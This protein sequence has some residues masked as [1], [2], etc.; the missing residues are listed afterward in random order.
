MRD[1]R[2]VRDAVILHDLG[3]VVHALES[4]DELK[5]RSHDGVMVVR[6]VVRFPVNEGTRYGDAGF[7]VHG[8]P[9]RSLDEVLEFLNGD[10]HDV[11]KVQW[12]NGNRFFDLVRDPNGFV[13]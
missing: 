13:V 4:G 5:L 7:W 1:V 9:A 11:S 2:F 6:E 8:S 10:A 3:S 12:F